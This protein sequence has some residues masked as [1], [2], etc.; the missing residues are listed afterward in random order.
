M[1]TLFRTVVFFVALSSCFTALSAAVQVDVTQ[2][3]GNIL[4]GESS[5]IIFQVRD[6]GV[7]DTSDSSTTISVTPSGNGRVIG[8]SSANT[9]DT[10]NVDG[11]TVNATVGSGIAVFVLTSFV[12]QTVTLTISSNTTYS[13]LS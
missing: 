4:A 11:G 8:V 1:P 9:N 10:L 5:T 6:G 7:L 12:D 2:A 13:D 3:A